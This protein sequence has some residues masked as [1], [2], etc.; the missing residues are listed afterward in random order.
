MLHPSENIAAHKA[1]HQ[2]CEW[3]VQITGGWTGGLQ[4][5][6]RTVEELISSQEPGSNCPLASYYMFALTHVSEPPCASVSSL[7]EWYLCHGLLSESPDNCV[8]CSLPLLPVI[9]SSLG[10]LAPPLNQDLQGQGH[11]GWFYLSTWHSLEHLRRNLHRGIASISM[12]FGCVCEGS[13]GLLINPV[14]QYQASSCESWA[15]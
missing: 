13:S 14:G 8:S 4:D 10:I 11:A 12:A 5:S 9:I 15:M 2:R 7:I 3:H 6:R 1:S